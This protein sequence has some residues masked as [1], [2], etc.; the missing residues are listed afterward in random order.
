M[1]NYY[2]QPI[3]KS[4]AKEMIVKNHYSH[5]F[6]K[7]TV[8]LGLFE[9]QKDK[10]F[11]NDNDKLIGCLTY[12]DPIGFR[13]ADSISTEITQG[14]VLELTRLY[15]TD[16][17]PKNMESWAISQSFKYLK[18]NA[19]KIKVLVSYADPS[20]GHTGIIYQATNW[21]CT[22]SYQSG[23]N[24][25]SFDSGK[26]WKHPKSLS[27][28]HGTNV[29]QKLSNLFKKETWAKQVPKKVKYIYILT[30]KK[31]KKKILNTLK[32]PIIDYPKQNTYSEP[33][34][35]KYFPSK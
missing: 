27:S 26:T 10:F 28:I 12:G 32:N 19:P 8:A 34:I 4:I 24:L 23:T 1:N 16:D 31:E 17:T 2:I 11:E 18:Q 13:C 20:A 35:K 22:E 5:K 21:I 7:C 15:I 3:P 6:S 25:I 9:R 30:N 33:Q 14:Q 29:P